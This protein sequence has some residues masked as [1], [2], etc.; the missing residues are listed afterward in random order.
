MR[1]AVVGGGTSG[2]AIQH[3]VEQRGAE[4]VVMS[5]S[6]GFDVR[7]AQASDRLT[8]FDVVI[9]AVGGTFLR[10]R[11]AEEFF[12]TSTRTIAR[13]TE[14]SGT[15]HV[16][17]SIVNCDLPEVRGYGYF[18]AKAEQERVAR[19]V[20]P[21]LSIVRSTQWFEFAGQ[22]QQR[23][24]VGPVS[25][26]PAMQIQPVAL[27]AVAETIAEEALSDRPHDLVEVAGPETM[28]LQ[29]LTRATCP[30]SPRPVVV[31]I[32]TTYGKA[33]TNGALLPPP[34]TPIVGPVLSDWL[35]SRKL[36]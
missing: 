10:R 34:T 25:I 20:S 35:A 4:C 27:D 12:T 8:E 13:A 30:P 23:M 32:P 11:P 2:L 9:E 28:T 26:V 31:T 16:L 6:T 14:S 3:A 22:N 1:V 17:L 33:F 19:Q 5:R 7:D 21:R 36:Q 29:E 18:A 24:K 15:R